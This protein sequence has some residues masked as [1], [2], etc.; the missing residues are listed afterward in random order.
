MKPLFCFACIVFLLLLFFIPHTQHGRMGEGDSV[1]TAPPILSQRRVLRALP[2]SLFP[3]FLEV[4][5]T[6]THTHI[7]TRVANRAFLSHND[8]RGTTKKKKGNPFTLRKKARKK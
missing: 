5:L 1:R 6:Q 2:L 7:H 8:E 4:H 3:L